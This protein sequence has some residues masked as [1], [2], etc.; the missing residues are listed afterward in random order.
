M[1]AISARSNDEKPARGDGADDSSIPHARRV[2]LAWRHLIL[3]NY[4][5]DTLACPTCGSRIYIENTVNDPLEVERN[6][7]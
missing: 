2:E 1:I 5:A 6:L 3:P 7:R 4:E